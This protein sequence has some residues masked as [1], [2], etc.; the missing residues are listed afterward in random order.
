MRRDETIKLMNDILQEQCRLNQLDLIEA[1]GASQYEAGV[2]SAL[3]NIEE[4]LDSV[5]AR[6]SESSP[7]QSECAM[8]GCD[9][10][11]RYCVIHGAAATAPAPY[12]DHETGMTFG[13]H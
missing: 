8:E 6:A 7:P 5:A 13:K 10:V 3:R 2:T 9:L 11:A 1:Y 4:K 12:T